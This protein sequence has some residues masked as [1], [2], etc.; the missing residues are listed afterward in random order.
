MKVYTL[1]TCVCGEFGCMEL[2]KIFET[3]EAAITYAEL[4]G[5]QNDHYRLDPYVDGTEYSTS[6]YEVREMEVFPERQWK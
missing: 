6:Y 4:A 3:R 5:Y 1:E 2:W